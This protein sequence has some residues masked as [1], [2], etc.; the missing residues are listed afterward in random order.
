MQ[1]A[2]MPR[3]SARAAFF[4]GGCGFVFHGHLSVARDISEFQHS[5]PG[6]RVTLQVGTRL[7]VIAS[8]SA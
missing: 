5:H 6:V 4:S 3:S 7:I 2:S 1:A 8:A